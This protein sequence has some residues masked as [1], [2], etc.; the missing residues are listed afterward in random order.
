MNLNEEKKEP[1]RSQT[2]EY[3]KKLLSM[4]YLTRKVSQK[5]AFDIVPSFVFFFVIKNSER[6]IFFFAES[7]R[8]PRRT[9]RRTGRLCCPPSKSPRVELKKRSLNHLIPSSG[10]DEPNVG[11]GETVR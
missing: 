3:K 8:R 1:L 4:N 6:L 10:L 2:L 9:L 7:A 11:M 5:R